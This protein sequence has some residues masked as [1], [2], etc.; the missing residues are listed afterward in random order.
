MQNKCV[1]LEFA[2]LRQGDLAVERMDG[3]MARA[4]IIH[5]YPYK[6]R[7][8]WLRSLYLQGRASPALLR[9]FTARLSRHTPHSLKTLMELHMRSGVDIVAPTIDEHGNFTL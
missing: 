4:D 1:K 2:I 7:W 6:D 8:R 5:C 3:A 9:A